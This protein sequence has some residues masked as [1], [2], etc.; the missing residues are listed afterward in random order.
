MLGAASIRTPIS[1]Q[2]IAD[3]NHPLPDKTQDF[4]WPVAW[5]WA[6]LHWFLPKVDVI[7]GYL[8]SWVSNQLSAAVRLIPLGPTKSQVLQNKLLPV[9]NQQAEILLEENPYE[10]WT[11]DV[12]ATMAQISHTELYSKLFRS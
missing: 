10:L 4:S 12:G 6:G 11:G 8:Y 1:L 5:S 9:I 3:L 7:K 2:L